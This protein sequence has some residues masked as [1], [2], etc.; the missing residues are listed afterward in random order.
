M[1]RLSPMCYNNVFHLILP[2]DTIIIMSRTAFN[3]LQ[4]YFRM[5]QQQ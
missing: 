4:L 1:I 2:R 5:E 3:N